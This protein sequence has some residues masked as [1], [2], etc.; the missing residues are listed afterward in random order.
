MTEEDDKPEETQALAEA[1]DERCPNCHSELFSRNVTTG[2]SAVPGD[3]VVCR[4]CGAFLE[5]NEA[6]QP[7]QIS[8]AA[9]KAL[10]KGYP[11]MYRVMM[12]MRRKVL[13]SIR[14]RS[15]PAPQ[16]VH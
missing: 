5:I 12:A 2:R 9:V 8:V 7:V 14:K 15:K 16:R 11:T 10:T 1:Q 6:G 3:C 13:L 4:M